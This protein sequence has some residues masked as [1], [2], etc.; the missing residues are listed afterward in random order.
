MRLI[1]ISIKNSW[2]LVHPLVLYLFLNPARPIRPEAMRGMGVGSGMRVPA[3]MVKS[4]D[5]LPKNASG[6]PGKL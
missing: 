4:A 3:A 1:A 6:Q 2:L 5:S